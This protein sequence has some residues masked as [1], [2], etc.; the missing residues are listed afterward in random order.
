MENPFVSLRGGE[1]VSVTRTVTKLLPTWAG[2][3]VQEKTPLT[4][5]MVAF[6]GAPGSRL[7]LSELPSGSVAVA[8]T[9]IGKPATTCWLEIA[10]REGGWLV[11]VV[12]CTSPPLPRP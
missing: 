11:K 5:L 2:A 12:N 3:G 8:F 7:K 4:A 6:E 10:A 1:P 9:T